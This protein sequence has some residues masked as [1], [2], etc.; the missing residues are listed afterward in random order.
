MSGVGARPGGASG[1]CG[2]VGG[3]GGGGGDFG[4]GVGVVFRGVWGN[5]ARW[6]AEVRRG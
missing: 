1:G 5:E 6:C 3:G 2:G 4:G